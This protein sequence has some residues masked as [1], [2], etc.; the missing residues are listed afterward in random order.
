MPALRARLKSVRGLDCGLGARP[1]PSLN[2]HGTKRVLLAKF[3]VCGTYSVAV[4]R[5]Q[6]NKQTNIHL[7]NICKIIVHFCPSLHSKFQIHD[8]LK[9]TSPSNLTNL[10][11]ADVNLIT[12][13]EFGMER[14]TKT[15]YNII[16]LYVL[17][18]LGVTISSSLKV[19]NPATTF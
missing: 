13:L 16:S 9:V 19:G 17:E 2:L 14:G 8:W 18:L 3:E 5:S 10:R 1:R 12:N 4:H 7:T 15:H 11:S 6:T